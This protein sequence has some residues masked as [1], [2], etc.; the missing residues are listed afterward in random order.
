VDRILQRRRRRLAAAAALIPRLKRG[1]RVLCVGKQPRTVSTLY[2]R[3]HTITIVYD[4]YTCYMTG[5]SWCLITILTRGW[6][7]SNRQRESPVWRLC[8]DNGVVQ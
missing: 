4:T 5:K 6:L 2:R 7:V 8:G 1:F 3:D